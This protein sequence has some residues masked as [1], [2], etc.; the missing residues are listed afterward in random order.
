MARKFVLVRITAMRGVNLKVFDFDY[1][2]TWVGF[3][4]N[5]DQKVYGRY[6]GRD[7]S[8]ADAHLS[9]TGLKN[10]MLH[11]LDNYRRDP[12][13]GPSEAVEPPFSPEMYPTAKRLK[14]DACIHCH[15]VND[16]RRDSLRAEGKWK[17]DEI[18][19]YPPPENVGFTLDADSG[20]GVRSVKPGSPASRAGLAPGDTLISINGMDVA[21]FADAQYALHKSPVSGA[22]P[23]VVER[24]G[25]R[26]A[27][28]LRLD[29]DWRKTDISW[30]ASMW[31]LEP[32]AGVHGK[33]LT[34][35]EKASLGLGP[36]RLAFR[37]GDWL[38]K[39]AKGAGIRVGDIILG[40]DGKAL[41]M[42]ML[43]FNVYVRLNYKVGDQI[44]YNVLRD[45][46]R[47][48]LPAVL[49]ARDTF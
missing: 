11:A 45:G 2:L 22:V 41:E 24:E 42:T 44:V 27:A 6:G 39:Q 47:L 33:D 48:D 35:S 21:S 18:W 30:R 25:K 19:V 3:F 49:P 1:D 14:A 37:H 43:Q 46:K 20:S 16:L 17:R 7:A 12:N 13:G 28:R 15:Q 38:T 26:R 23:I 9:M 34:A 40:V 5:A 10:A 8:A 32:A 4:M 29:P 31:G 36:S